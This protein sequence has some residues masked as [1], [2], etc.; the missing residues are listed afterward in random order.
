[1]TFLEKLDAAVGKNNSLLCV[2]LDPDHTRLPAGLNQFEFN[3]AI[4]DATAD[5]V[6]AFKPNPAFYE[7]LG[8]EGIGYLEQTCAYIK[9]NHPDIPI[10]FDFKRG[11][12]G[13]TNNAYAEFAFDRLHADAVTLHTYLGQEAIQTFL[14]YQDKGIFLMVRTSNPG[15]GEFQDLKLEGTPLYQHV[16]QEIVDKWNANANCM[17]IVGAT[18]P[19]EAKIL[20]RIAGN[21]MPFLMPGLGAQGADAEAA[22]K[23]GLTTTGK[24]LVINASRDIIFASAEQDFA[25][26]ARQKATELRDQINSYRS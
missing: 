9:T 2:G 22:V 1:M 11:D 25:D 4:I 6:C 3:K 17:F 21:T 13:N 26:V 7:A 24:G 8:S 10:I 18:Y 19:E 15:A 14:D 23:G 5:L 20:R 16:A 12:I